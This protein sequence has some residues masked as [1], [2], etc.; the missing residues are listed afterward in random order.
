MFAD[1]LQEWL[2]TNKEIPFIMS[3][4]NPSLYVYRN[5]DKNE[6]LFMVCYIDDCCYFGSSKELEAK[7]GKVLKKQF[8]LEL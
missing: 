4:V 3:E 2:I 8:N 7:F 5:V 1:D 6:Y